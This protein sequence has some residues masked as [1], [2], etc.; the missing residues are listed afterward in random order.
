MASSI[1]NTALVT[2]LFK[3]AAGVERAFHSALS[4]GYGQEDVAARSG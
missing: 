4:R 2:A 3:D 1:G